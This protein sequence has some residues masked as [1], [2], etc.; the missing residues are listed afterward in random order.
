MRTLTFSVAIAAALLVAFPG[1]A[2]ATVAAIAG[3]SDSVDC[4]YPG[5]D[6]DP[7]VPLLSR[8]NRYFEQHETEGVTID[9][10]F[11]L[12]YTEAVR[13]SVVSQLLAYDEL[14]K[15]AP[16]RRLRQDLVDHA[17]F[18]LRNFDVVRSQTPFDGMLGSSLLGAYA[19]TRN[20]A[21]LAQG[22][23]IVD[24]L[25]ATPTWELILNGGLMAAIALADYARITG[26][27]AA[28]QK[29][30]DI[31]AMLPGFQNADGS[32]PHW[33]SG[34]EDVHYT[35]WMSMELILLERTTGDPLIPPALERMHDFMETRID[36]AGRT[37]YEEPCDDYPGCT[38]YY[39][40]I[41]SG[42][43]YD[44]DTRA[45]TNELGYSVLLLDHFRSPKYWAVTSFLDALE[46]G[47][48]IPDKWDFWPPPGDP[49]YPWAIADTS[50]VNM[51]VIF[52]SLA[53]ALTGRVSAIS[54]EL[55]WA[56]DAGEDDPDQSEAIVLRERHAPRRCG[57][58]V[59]SWGLADSLFA[60]GANPALPCSPEPETGASASERPAPVRPAGGRLGM[61]A[62]AAVSG[63]PASLRI[64]TILPNPVRRDCEVRFELPAPAGVSLA[65]FDASGRRVRDLVSG[66]RAAGEGLA[67][68]DRR[69]AGG[70]ACPSGVYFLRLRAGGETR[71]ARLLVLR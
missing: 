15:I 31:L 11:V 65:I 25:Q 55:A 17:D 35:D 69:D 39:Y 36:G 21:Y 68:W 38:R 19:V 34:S 50:V 5:R 2:P 24:Q 6:H 23:V 57:A 43:S 46:N 41:A 7:L 40:S 9:S 27:A 48:A 30:Q 63:L 22:K 13:L 66:P 8:M 67:R 61:A 28:A 64:A 26:D 56:L 54:T 53:C 14:C 20:P 32:F 3:G 47:G 44:Y 51:S 70:V 29:T 59:H 1:T 45:W 58:R 60:A 16:S 12:N 49:Y 62:P 52:W 18:L 71:S 42:C 33:C 10:R 4:R 37:R